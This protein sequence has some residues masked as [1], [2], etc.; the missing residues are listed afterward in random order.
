MTFAQNF[1]HYNYT[2]YGKIVIADVLYLADPL[3]LIFV[4]SSVDEVIVHL[5][6]T[7]KLT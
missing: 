5:H 3:Y 6:G 2:Y 7:V 4:L 1:I